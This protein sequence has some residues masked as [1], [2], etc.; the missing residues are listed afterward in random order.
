MS[1]LIGV[2]M[3]NCNSGVF[4]GLV[5]LNK[6]CATA[7]LAAAIGASAQYNNQQQPMANPTDTPLNAT[8]MKT[9]LY[10]FSSPGG[11]T[12][13]RLSAAGLIVVDGQPPASYSA[14]RS[15]I[16]K[17]SDQ[18][19]RVLLLTDHDPVH[20]GSDAKFQ[21]DGTRLLVQENLQENLK[22]NPSGDDPP[23]DNTTASPVIYDREYTLK[24]GG[25]EAQLFHFGNARTSGDT[26]VYFPNLK[27]VAVGDLLV[28]TPNPDYSAGGSLVE[29]GPVLEQV[30]KLDF[31]VVVPG[32]GPAATRAD[33]QTFKNKI[34]ALVSRA[35]VLV[36]KGVP[37][38]QLMAQLKTA[39]LG[40]QLNLSDDQVDHFYAELARAK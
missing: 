11:N 31:D 35:A 25:V 22:R 40:W 28:A 36:K 12:L 20:S 8:M 30:L 16:R 26:V 27:V 21:A 37:K 29:W 3:R 7:L 5:R 19:I 33:L 6:M 1:V 4:M 14:L 2:P 23:T 17:I 38:E 32:A 15:R 18:P 10:L 9:G 13:L 24:L 34:D 39:D